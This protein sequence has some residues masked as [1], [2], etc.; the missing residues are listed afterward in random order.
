MEKAVLQHWIR[1]SNTYERAQGVITKNRVKNV[2]RT[3][4]VGN[5]TA[6]RTAR[7]S[8]D[9]TISDHPR[10]LSEITRSCQICAV[11]TD[12]AIYKFW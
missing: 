1:H 3:G 7:I 6:Y 10:C 11:T 9:R 12:D 2:Y 5:T 4:A 8:A